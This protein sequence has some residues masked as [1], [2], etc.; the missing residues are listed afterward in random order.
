[1]AKTEE[2]TF[3]GLDPSTT[4]ANYA[5]AITGDFYYNSTTGQF[6]TV[7]TGGAPIGTW[8]SGGNLNTQD[9]LW[10]A[11]ELKQL[12]CLLVGYFNPPSANTNEQYDSAWTEIQMI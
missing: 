2:W 8:A 11:L 6:K 7:N 9:N 4:P 10:L 5:D 1:M 3:T 12:S